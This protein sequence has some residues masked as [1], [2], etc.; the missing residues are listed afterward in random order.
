MTSIFRTI[1]AGAAGIALVIFSHAAA[2]TAADG[3]R[4]GAGNKSHEPVAISVANNGKFYCGPPVENRGGD[5]VL[6]AE[7]LKANVIVDFGAWQNRRTKIHIHERMLDRVFRAYNAE[8]SSDNAQP[9]RQFIAEEITSQNDTTVAKFEKN[10]SP[11]PSGQAS[12]VRDRASS[13]FG[14]KARL[15]RLTEVS[16]GD[17]EIAVDVYFRIII[18]TTHQARYGNGISLHRAAYVISQV[19]IR[20]EGPPLR[21]M[22]F[23]FPPNRRPFRMLACFTESGEAI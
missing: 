18:D 4:T 21:E 11:Q 15:G 1:L 12:M 7:T 13:C 3:S 23:R 16:D 6:T 20:A 22:Y 9:Y 19:P 10:A 2:V 8:G 14:Y 5:V 17:L